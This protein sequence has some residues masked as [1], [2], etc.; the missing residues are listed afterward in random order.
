[1]VNHGLAWCSAMVTHDASMVNH[2]HEW[3]RHVTS[4]APMVQL[5]LWLAIVRS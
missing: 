1:M 5:Y 2:G 4:D 3:P